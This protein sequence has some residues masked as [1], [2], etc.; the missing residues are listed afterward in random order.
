[1]SWLAAWLP[2]SLAR[3]AVTFWVSQGAGNG[4]RTNELCR[5]QQLRNGTL[6]HSHTC[7]CVAMCK[8]MPQLAVA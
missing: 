2:G 6:A 5:F 7:E 4:D 3:S 1:M 8:D